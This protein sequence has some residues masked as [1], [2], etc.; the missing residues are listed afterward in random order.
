MKSHTATACYL[1]PCQGNFW[2]YFSVGL[3]AKAAWGFHSLREDSPALTSSR[4]ANQF[5]YT[6]FS[7]TSGTQLAALGRE[8][9]AGVG[10]GG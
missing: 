2:N 8:S 10:V 1:L 7:C 9:L 3:D 6:F 4:L 5:W